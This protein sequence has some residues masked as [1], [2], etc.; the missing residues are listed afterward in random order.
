MLLHVCVAI[1]FVMIE[2]IEASWLHLSRKVVALYF[3]V[4]VV[5]VRNSIGVGPVVANERPMQNHYLH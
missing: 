5:Y 1:N 3:S 4:F 2:E